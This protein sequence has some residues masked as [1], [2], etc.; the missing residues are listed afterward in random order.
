M[1]EPVRFVEPRTLWLEIGQLP[2]WPERAG[3]LRGFGL[4]QG[5]ARSNEGRGEHHGCRKTS[6]NYQPI[7]P[8]WTLELGSV[9]GN[10]G[11]VGDEKTGCD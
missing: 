9:R 5:A 8:G 11:C 1:L 3:F 6:G 10:S 2:L 4:G 7:H